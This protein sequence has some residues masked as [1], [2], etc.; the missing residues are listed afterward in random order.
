MV[1]V[2]SQPYLETG[3]RLWIEYAKYG[4]NESTCDFDKTFGSLL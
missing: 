1:V 4:E 2:S 3:A